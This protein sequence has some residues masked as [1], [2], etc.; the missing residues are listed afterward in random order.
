M[1][2]SHD[3]G[4]HLQQTCSFRTT[5][6]TFLFVICSASFH[7][8]ESLV[9][10]ILTLL[11]HIWN[12]CS[13]N[14]VSQIS[15]LV[16]M[17]LNLL[18]QSVFETFSEQCGFQHVTTSSYYPQANRFIERNV[19]TVKNI[20]QK[21][22][23]SGADPH[24]TMLCLRTTPVDHHLPSPAELLNSREY[25]SN[26]PTMTKPV[27][28]T[29]NTGMLMWSCKQDRIYRSFT[30]T[31]RQR[32]YQ[33]CTL[34]TMYV[35]SIPWIENGNVVWLK[36]T[37]KSYVVDIEGGNALIWNHRHIRQSIE[38]VVDFRDQFQ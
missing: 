21:C 6:H 9:V 35:C 37:P 17:T 28:F 34:A 31:D 8:F 5:I 10:F 30:T 32:N 29:E 13:K 27:L 16:E 33:N 3:H 19:Q 1:M 11:L 7:W 23:K 25:Q 38:P 22:K 20:L 14:T 2:F 24:L 26:L 36:K 4:T 12:Q 15:W 18:P